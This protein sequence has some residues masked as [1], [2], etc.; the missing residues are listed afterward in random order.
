MK[1][2]SYQIIV[3]AMVLASMTAFKAS[4]QWSN[5]A[6]SIWATDLTKNVGIGTNLP[7]AKL[8]LNG[9]QRIY[10]GILWMKSCSGTQI[11][12]NACTPVVDNWITSY[13]ENA[14]RVWVINTLN[15]SDNNSFGIYS[16]AY[17]YALN[18]STSGNVGIKTKA[19]P[20][21]AL[22]ICGSIRA[23][24]VRV[25]T[26][27][28]DYVFDENYK[29]PSLYEVEQFVIFIENIIAPTCF[30]PNFPSPD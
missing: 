9:N 2:K 8:H 4:A 5:N 26:G 29:L 21:Y 15:R 13:D 22:S 19:S 25:E 14:N 1:K 17:G 23:R 7:V 12:M 3:V 28:C 11:Q 6:A 16:Q 30:H 20:N 27:W 24:E 10:N 18:I